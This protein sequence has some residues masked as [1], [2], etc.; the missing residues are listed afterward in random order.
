[1]NHL[2]QR[3][4]DHIRMPE[5][6]ARALRTD[7]ASRCSQ[8]ETEVIF[9]NKKTI[10]RRPASL[11]VAILLIA[12]LSVTALACGG[13]VL[14][15]ILSDDEIPAVTGTVYDLTDQEVETVPYEYTEENGEIWVTFP[16]ED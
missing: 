1:M 8:P 2:Y 6:R 14:Y 3:T 9:M 15:R 13:R 11:L 12:A 10:L 4:F 5:D 16:T 7:L